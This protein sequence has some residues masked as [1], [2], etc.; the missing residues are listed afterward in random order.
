MLRSPE[1]KER[2][3]SGEIYTIGS[4]SLASVVL[5]LPHQMFYKHSPNRKVSSG[6]SINGLPGCRKMIKKRADE[7]MSS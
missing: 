4:G 1:G 6:V 7:V 3:V 2:T 5:F